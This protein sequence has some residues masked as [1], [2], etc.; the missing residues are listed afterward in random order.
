MQTKTKYHYYIYL[1][2]DSVAINHNTPTI[3]RYFASN[4]SCFDFLLLVL[5]WF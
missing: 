5:F 1:G 4:C 2:A 3:P